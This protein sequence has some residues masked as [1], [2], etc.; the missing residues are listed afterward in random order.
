[1]TPGSPSDT[2]CSCCRTHQMA[3]RAHLQA[4][5]P[6]SSAGEP[7]TPP[8]S[9]AA[10][11]WESPAN[12]FPKKT[13]GASL[14][15]RSANETSWE[16]R[17]RQPAVPPSQEAEGLRPKDWKGTRAPRTAAPRPSF[18]RS[19][20]RA[21]SQ[22]RP[23]CGD[24]APPRASVALCGLSPW[25]EEGPRWKSPLRLPPRKTFFTVLNGPGI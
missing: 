25:G 6:L 15:R 14:L 13:Y 22:H 12:K 23:S 16:G 4:G 1:M 18:H 7:S 3:W 20:G 8:S 11:R 10:T 2:R 24:W 17:G 5:T 9:K 19:P 21:A